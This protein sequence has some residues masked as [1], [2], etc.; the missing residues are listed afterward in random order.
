[1]FLGEVGGGTRGVGSLQFA[2]ETKE[3]KR[4]AKRVMPTEDRELFIAETG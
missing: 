1:M 2:E 3:R 4:R